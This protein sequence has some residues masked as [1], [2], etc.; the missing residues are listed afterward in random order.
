MKKILF[1]LL[2]LPTLAYADRLGG[3]NP[4]SQ[5]LLTTQATNG[6]PGGNP[7]N[8]QFNSAGTFGGIITTTYTV[9]DNS[10]VIGAT[11]TFLGSQTRFLG[12]VSITVTQGSSMTFT[13]GST[14]AVNGL[15]LASSATVTNLSVTT[16]TTRVE[17][18]TSTINI[19]RG[20]FMV[21]DDNASASGKTIRIRSGG[22]ID[23]RMTLVLPQAGGSAGDY[24][25]ISAVSG[26]AQDGIYQLNF[27]TPPAGTYVTG[28]LV[29]SAATNSNTPASTTNN[30]WFDT[31]IC[32]TD[33]QL[34][35]FGSINRITAMGMLGTDDIGLTTAYATI[36]RDGSDIST[37]GIG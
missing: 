5:V 35:G 36:L 23:S 27:V 28:Q 34:G 18:I 31:G 14:L 4:N 24:M 20:A 11:T 3:L 30:T 26:T 10:L 29:R 16:S 13:S 12:N 37:G 9:A 8:L 7:G 19:N 2:F 21:F 33:T 32:A 25:R 1:A 15:L 17:V 22:L 6:T